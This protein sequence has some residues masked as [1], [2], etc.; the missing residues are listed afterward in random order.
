MTALISYYYSHVVSLHLALFGNFCWHKQGTSQTTLPCCCCFFI[1]CFV[2]V[3]WGFYF[4]YL[5]YFS[6]FLKFCLVSYRFFYIIVLILVLYFLKG[7]VGLHQ[8][9]I[10]AHL[11]LFKGTVTCY[12]CD[13]EPASSCEKKFVTCPSGHVSLLSHRM[14]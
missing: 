11:I 1:S 12:S 3:F 10:Q 8:L 5:I 7:W 13:G 9:K 2:S 6:Y 4:V 14:I